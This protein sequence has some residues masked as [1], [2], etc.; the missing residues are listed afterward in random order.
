MAALTVQTNGSPNPTQ[1]VAADA[2]DF[3]FAA[4][5]PGGDTAAIEDGDILLVQ[6]VNAGAQTFTMTSQPDALRRTGTITTYSL[7]QDELA[8]F[9]LKREGWADASGNLNLASSD[10]DIKYAWL[11]KG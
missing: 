1:P 5:V 2:L 3:T 9:F 7:V 6:N 10:A 11:R 8:F 4:S